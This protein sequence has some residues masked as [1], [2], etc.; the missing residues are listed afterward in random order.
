MTT[1]TLPLDP[2]K[3]WLNPMPFGDEWR[4]ETWRSKD[5]DYRRWACDITGRGI[6]VVDTLMR[7]EQA[8]ELRAKGDSRSRALLETYFH[9]FDQIDQEERAA[10][11]TD[12]SPVLDHW[13]SPPTGER[14]ALAA[15]LDKAIRASFDAAH[16]KVVKPKVH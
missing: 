5:E 16:P 11:L 1:G 7:H 10:G 8:I 9:S 13:L 4:R 12:A 2:P 6:P 15:R 3:L 14:R